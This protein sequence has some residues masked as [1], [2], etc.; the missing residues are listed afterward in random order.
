M[1][2]VKVPFDIGDIV[3]VIYPSQPHHPVYGTWKFSKF[4]FDSIIG[5]VHK[6]K[7]SYEVTGPN[8]I[9]YELDPG[10]GGGIHPD[11]LEMVSPTSLCQCNLSRLITRGCN[12]GAFKAEKADED[13]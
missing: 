7:S 1:G 3:K 5:T 4:L 11:W 12:C 8:D 2:S 10:N 9:W 6:I 13:E